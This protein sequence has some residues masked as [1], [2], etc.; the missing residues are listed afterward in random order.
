VSDPKATEPATSYQAASP[1]KASDN[2][3]VAITNGTDSPQTDAPEVQ[4]VA[5]PEVDAQAPATDTALP[6]DGSIPP[7]FRRSKSE[8]NPA[9]VTD[10]ADAG[11]PDRT[12]GRATPADADEETID[13][14]KNRKTEQKKRKAAN[15][16]AKLKAKQSGELS[17]MPLQGKAAIEFINA[18]PIE[19]VPESETEIAAKRDRLRAHADAIRDLLKKSVENVIAIGRRLTEAKDLVSHGCWLPWLDTEFGWHIKTARRYMQLYELSLKWDNLSLL[20]PSSAYLLAQ[21]STPDS[22]RQEVL[23]RAKAGKEITVVEVKSTIAANRAPRSQGSGHR[24]AASQISERA[25]P[26]QHDPS[27]QEATRAVAEALRSFKPD[28][29]RVIVE[30][31]FKSLEEEWQCPNQEEE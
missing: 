1:D 17:R 19:P 10:T 16:I 20:N 25:L 29:R 27:M 15:R 22:A 12:N 9:P 21:D 13:D 4:A 26:P 6:A 14:I 7:C 11:I 28:V 24:A 2:G 23:E 30:R 3:L 5:V 8:S 31:A 18:P